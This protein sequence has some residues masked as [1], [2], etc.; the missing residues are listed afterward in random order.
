[1][2]NED[3][4]KPGTITGLSLERANVLLLQVRIYV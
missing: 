2:W 3:V 1:M 4:R